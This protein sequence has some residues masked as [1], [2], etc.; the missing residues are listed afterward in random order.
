MIRVD[1][2]KVE[3]GQK[4]KNEIRKGRASCLHYTQAGSVTALSSTVFFSKQHSLISSSF[5]Y[6]IGQNLLINKLVKVP[7]IPVFSFSQSP[8][9]SYH[10]SVWF[11]FHFFSAI[12][13]FFSFILRLTRV[14][15]VCM[16]LVDLNRVGSVLAFVYDIIFK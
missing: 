5:C 4:H 10:Y 8:L 2:I 6:Q 14:H 15:Q 16:K 7:I 3:Q 1:R 13:S 12:S 9:L 11:F